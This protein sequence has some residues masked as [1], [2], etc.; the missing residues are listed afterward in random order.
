MEQVQQGSG[1]IDLAI[2]SSFVIYGCRDFMK[3]SLSLVSSSIKSGA[4]IPFYKV[5]EKI[6]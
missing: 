1:G 6:S 3:A 5:D 4:I 2:D